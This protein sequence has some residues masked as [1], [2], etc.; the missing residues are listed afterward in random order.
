VPKQQLLFEQ[1]VGDLHIEVLKTYY[2]AFAREVFN[3]T[4]EDA[5][6]SH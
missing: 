2:E 4:D 1:K 3:N 5:L 6:K